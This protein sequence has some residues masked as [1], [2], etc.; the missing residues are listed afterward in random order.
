MADLHDPSSGDESGNESIVA[1]PKKDK[2]MKTQRR[3]ERRFASKYKKTLRHRESLRS[4]LASRVLEMDNR[5]KDIEDE[6]EIMKNRLV[7]AKVARRRLAT[8]YKQTSKSEEFDLMNAI[9]ESLLERNSPG[10]RSVIVLCDPT[11]FNDA[12]EINKVRVESV[13]FDSFDIAFDK[14]KPALQEVWDQVKHLFSI[15]AYSTTCVLRKDLLDDGS[16]PGHW[17]IK[18]C[19]KHNLGF[20]HRRDASDD[21]SGLNHDG[22]VSLCEKDMPLNATIFDPKNIEY[23]AALGAKTATL[24]L[25]LIRPIEDVQSTITPRLHRVLNDA[26]IRSVVAPFDKM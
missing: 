17:I 20:F 12:N 16:Q 21:R 13:D 4:K 14:D 1:V 18:N 15:D 2:S 19:V 7:E 26:F 6:M 9:V 24:K 10:W 11:D 3:L 23:D 25:I 22:F 8:F 5:V